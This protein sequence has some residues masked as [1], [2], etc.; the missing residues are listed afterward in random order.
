MHSILQM[1][2]RFALGAAIVA[3]PSATLDAASSAR[4]CEACPEMVLLSGG[5]FIMGTP[6]A[7]PERDDD[8]GPQRSVTVQ[9]Y[10]LGKFEVTR[11]EFAA[12]VKATGHVA[13]NTCYVLDGG[14]KFAETR[15]RSWRNPGFQQTDRHPV[16]CVGREDARAYAD[17]LSAKTGRLYRLPSEAEW[18]YAARA[19]TETARPWGNDQNLAC[20]HANVADRNTRKR[21]PGWTIHRCDDRTFFTASAGQFRSS[22]WGIHDLMGNVWEWTEDCA[23]DSYEGA[24][25]DGRPWVGGDC[26]RR[27]LRGGSWYSHP[28]DVRAGYR[29]K[30]FATTRSSNA[31]FRVAR[32][33]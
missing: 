23:N 12:F 15:G 2:R 11:G 9:P 22:A 19:G 24:P 27:V 8:E 13:G 20:L 30:E 31:G 3:A 16:V 1:I 21:F 5:S 18:E 26:T 14:G 33:E 29:D 32:S 28:A 7:E 10:A 17:W 6:A 4:D 25:T